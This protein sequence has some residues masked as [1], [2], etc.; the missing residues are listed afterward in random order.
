MILVELSTDNITK[1]GGADGTVS[2]RNVQNRNIRNLMFRLTSSLCGGCYG[3]IFRSSSSER[4]SDGDRI[5]SSL[6][7][8]SKYVHSPTN[9]YG[10]RVS[11]TVSVVSVR[12]GDGVA[13]S[14]Q[15]LFQDPGYCQRCSG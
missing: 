8:T 15:S 9:K 10:I 4:D 13:I 3:I 14:S 11:E 1:E 5:L 7:S 12:V 6:L 2:E